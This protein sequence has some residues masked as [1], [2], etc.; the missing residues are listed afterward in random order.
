MTTGRPAVDVADL[1]FATWR[2]A[3]D[4]A[5]LL[6]RGENF[7]TAGRLLVVDLVSD[8]VP[9]AALARFL[10]VDRSTIRRWVRTHGGQ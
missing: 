7:T 3:R 8:G 5:Q 6:T 4:A 10:D 9:I 1:D 2:K